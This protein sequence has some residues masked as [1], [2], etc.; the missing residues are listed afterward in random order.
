MY[1]LFH[2]L[3]QNLIILGSSTIMNFLLFWRFSN[4][5]TP[6]PLGTN[7]VRL[8]NIRT[9]RMLIRDL[10]HLLRWLPPFLIWYYISLPPPFYNNRWLETLFQPRS[11]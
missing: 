7:W 8:E 5:L 2:C 3:W 1:F 4:T 9:L 11:D 10:V 6:S